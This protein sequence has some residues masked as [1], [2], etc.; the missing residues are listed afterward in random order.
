MREYRFHKVFFCCFQLTPNDITLDQLGHF[1]TN[2]VR[3]QQFAGFGVK[4]RFDHALGFTQCNRLAIPHEREPAHFDVKAR[5]FC[6]GFSIANA[7]HLRVA[8]C[9]ACDAFG[10]DGMRMFASDQISDHDAFVAGFVGQPRGACDI[11]NRV[12]PVHTCSAIGVC[13]DVCAIHF[14]TQ[15]FQTQTFDIANNTDR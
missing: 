8:I 3:A 1:C 9:T 15:F 10:F 5:L 14:D 12:Q 4:D 11:A 2:H 6:F 13:H 7:G